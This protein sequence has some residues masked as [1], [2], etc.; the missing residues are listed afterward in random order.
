MEKAR[1]NDRLYGT[2]AESLFAHTV[3]VRSDRDAMSNIASDT[4]AKLDMGGHGE[5]EG[6]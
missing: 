4:L 3:D 2:F 6:T 5:L 1:L